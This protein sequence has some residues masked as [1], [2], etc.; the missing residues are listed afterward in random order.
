MRS[1]EKG[2]LEKMIL[3]GT[4]SKRA[5]S[6][7]VLGRPSLCKKTSLEGNKRFT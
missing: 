1:P 5:G 7:K 3:E 2:D 6:G 4:D